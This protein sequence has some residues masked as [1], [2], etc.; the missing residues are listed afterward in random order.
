MCKAPVHLLYRGQIFG[1]MFL[2]IFMFLFFLVWVGVAHVHAIWSSF[3]LSTE[4]SQTMCNNVVLVHVYFQYYLQPGVL[5]A[6]YCTC[7]VYFTYYTICSM[8]YLSTC[9]S[10]TICSMLYLSTCISNII[11]S[12]LYLSTCISNTICSLLYLSTCISHTICSL[13]F[14]VC[15]TCPRV[16]L[17]ILML[18][19]WCEVRYRQIKH[20]ESRA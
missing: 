17:M 2:F 6:A 9:I 7:P 8:L 19:I 10:D 1:G 4:I 5:F 14:A 18:K 12:L 13:L 3:C 20:Q 15:C 11:C 16:F